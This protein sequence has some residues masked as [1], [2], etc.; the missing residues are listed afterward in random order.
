MNEFF[1]KNQFFLGITVA[2]LIIGVFVYFG[3]VN[4]KNGIVSDSA[5]KNNA[6]KTSSKEITGYINTG[7]V[8]HIENSKSGDLIIKFCPADVECSVEGIITKENK[9]NFKDLNSYIGKTITIQSDRIAGRQPENLDSSRPPIS[10][11]Q[12]ILSDP[13]QIKIVE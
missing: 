5:N 9:D 7:K 12:I 1:K 6:E 8:D 11:S 3:L 10:I 4:Q 2:A 13:S